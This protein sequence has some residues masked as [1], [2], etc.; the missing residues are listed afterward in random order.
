MEPNITKPNV[1]A[2]I[3]CVHAGSLDRAKDLVSL[4]KLCG[5]D[6]VKTQKRCPIE[7]VPKEMQNLPHPN[8]RFSYGK[9]YLEHRENLELSIEQH[10]ELKQHCESIGLKY[11]S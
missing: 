4:A 7:S 1:V 9:T 10:V 11:S 5:A 6:F 3:G 8:E 2:E